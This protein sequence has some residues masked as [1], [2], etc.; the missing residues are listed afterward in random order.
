MSWHLRTIRAR[1]TVPILLL[2]LLVLISIASWSAWREKSLVERLLQDKGRSLANLLEKIGATSIINYDYPTLESYVK[3]ATQDP[4]VAFVVFLDEKDKLLSNTS[5]RPAETSNLLILEREIKDEKGQLIGKLQMGYLRTNLQQQ[6]KNS[7]LTTTIVVGVALAI[8]ILGLYFIGRSISRQ[9]AAV[10]GNL[11]NTTD[12]L[13]AV[14]NSVMNDSSELAQVTA[15]EAATLQETSSGLKEAN[16]QSTSSALKAQ[17][18]NNLMQG[19]LKKV[20]EGEQSIQLLNHS[21]TEITQASTQT[22]QIIKTIHEIAFQTNL[23]ALNAAVEAARAGDAGKG[24]AVVASEVR[25]LANRAAQAA[26][27]TSQLIKQTNDSVQRGTDTVQT[28]TGIIQT[29]TQSVRHSTEL[30]TELSSTSREQAQSIQM[31]TNATQ[32]L[33]QLVQKSAQHADKSNATVHHLERQAEELHA[34]VQNLCLL[35]GQKN[36]TIIPQSTPHTN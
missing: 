21:M 16:T 17:E 29:M 32:Q 15:N 27:H 1:I 26:E 2:M 19:A 36:S 23:L 22:A 14:S 35:A 31:I 20:I 9:L 30:T 6:I 25:Q 7:L 10:I 24:F 4:D 12:Q 3:N 28:T 8:T 13:L 34:S 33:D 18:A 11:V 5:K